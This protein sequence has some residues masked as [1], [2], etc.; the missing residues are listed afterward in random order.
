MI[1]TGEKPFSCQ[2]C[3][4]LFRQKSHLRKHE[5]K[6]VQDIIEGPKSAYVA[7]SDRPLQ[8]DYCVKGFKEESALRRHT[9]IQHET[10]AKFKCDLC[11]YQSNWKRNFHRHLKASKY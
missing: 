7:S 1:H 6:H 11:E 5:A 2:Y 9:R 8:C 10:L 4:K 3:G